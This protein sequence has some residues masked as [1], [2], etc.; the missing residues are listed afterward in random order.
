MA[1]LAPSQRSSRAAALDYGLL[2]T[3]CVP[4]TRDAFADVFQRCFHPVGATP[5]ARTPMAVVLRAVH[6]TWD[7]LPALSKADMQAVLEEEANMSAPVPEGNEDAFEYAG[8]AAEAVARLH[9]VGVPLSAGLFSHGGVAGMTRPLSISPAQVLSPLSLV[10]ASAGEV[11]YQSTQTG[12][13]PPVPATTGQSLEPEVPSKVPGSIPGVSRDRATLLVALSTDGNTQGSDAGIEPPLAR[14]SLHG[15]E[16][17]GDV[18]R[19]GPGLPVGISAV[20]GWA[21][22]S[23]PPKA[24]LWKVDSL[25]DSDGLSTEHDSSED[26]GSGLPSAVGCTRVAMA[27]TDSTVPLS[28]STRASPSEPQYDEEE[29]AYLA[30]VSVAGALP[31]ISPC[32]AGYWSLRAGAAVWVPSWPRMMETGHG[33]GVPRSRVSC[34]TWLRPLMAAKTWMEESKRSL[35]L[36]AFFPVVVNTQFAMFSCSS[37]PPTAYTI[38]QDIRFFR[39]RRC[40]TGEAAIDNMRR[41]FRPRRDGDGGELCVLATLR[42]MLNNESM[43]LQ[44]LHRHPT[45][46]DWM[47]QVRHFSKQNTRSVRNMVAHLRMRV[48]Q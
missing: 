4:L 34:V 8:H 23:V 6:R 24:P 28:R 25:S 1:A 19:T 21:Q 36:P 22:V 48:S 30:E 37:L 43:A 33:F 9:S 42:L 20:P 40:G 16:R 47:C 45:A 31:E 17:R 18:C 32:S 29:L 35:Y 41:K 14:P 15:G 46:A 26:D 27:C 5:A 3:L 2:A 44:P 11:A 39:A 12:G 38:F 7:A 10:A 13:T